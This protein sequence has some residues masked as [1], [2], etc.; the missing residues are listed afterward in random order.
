MHR[1]KMKIVSLS[2]GLLGRVIWYGHTGIFKQ[3]N[4]GPLHSANSTS[5]ATVKPT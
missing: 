4:K 1:R 3:P 2:F 5:T